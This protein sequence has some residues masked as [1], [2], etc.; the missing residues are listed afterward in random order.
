MRGAMIV[1][2]E[3][4][5]EDGWHTTIRVADVSKF[6]A[7]IALNNSSNAYFLVLSLFSLDEAFS[8]SCCSLCYA[9]T[10]SFDHHGMLLLLDTL[11][12]LV[13]RI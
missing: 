12:L 9:P 10:T 8:F 7:T 3:T 2:M 4:R 13:R 1:M 6:H 11:R 5:M